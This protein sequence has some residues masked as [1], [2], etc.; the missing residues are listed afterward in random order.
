MPQL[1]PEDIRR[2]IV[3]HEERYEQRVDYLYCI[4]THLTI[5][6][7]LSPRKVPH[8]ILFPKFSTYYYE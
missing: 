1:R 4:G 3:I 6:Y 8:V 2:L 5:G 7:D